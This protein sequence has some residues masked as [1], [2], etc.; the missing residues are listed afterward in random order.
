M[1]TLSSNFLKTRHRNIL[2]PIGQLF[3]TLFDWMGFT[4]PCMSYRNC[5]CLSQNSWQV[6]KPSSTRLPCEETMFEEIL[7]IRM[8]YCSVCFLSNKIFRL[9][10]R[11]SSNLSDFSI[12][13]RTFGGSSFSLERIIN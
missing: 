6:L 10:S 2:E 8:F 3:A 7:L 13:S 11:N 4:L 12:F 1:H 5:I 9:I